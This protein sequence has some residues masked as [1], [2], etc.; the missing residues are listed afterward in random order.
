MIY[1]DH[2]ATS[3]LSP[4]S[5]AT[6][7]EA[8]E[9]FPGNPSSPHRLGARADAALEQARQRLASLLGCAPLD[10]VW[11]SGSTEA[12]NTVLHHAAAADPAAPA[13]IGAVEHPAVRESAR[14]HFRSRVDEIPVD[15]RGVVDL[16]WLKD[17]LAAQRPALV[18][19]MAANNETGVLQPWREAQELC[20]GAG[21]PFFCDATQWCGRLPA[22]GLGACGFVA[23][24]AHKFG[25]PRGVGFLKVP[26]AWPLRPLLWGGKQLEGRRAGTENV[27]GVL[28]MVA[29]LE[30]CEEQIA[31]G[32]NVQ[33]LAL[34]ERFQAALQ[35]AFP[36]V[37]L[38]GAGADRLWNTVSVVMPEADCRQ[39][40]VVKLDRAGFAVSTGSACASGS[41]QPSHVLTAMGL[42]SR[43]A[44]R[45]L[46][47]SSGWL[48]AE[49]EWNDLLKAMVRI[50]EDFAVSAAAI[51]DAP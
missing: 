45:A 42:S 50:Q 27:P 6:W 8:A 37:R 14:H 35:T 38:N 26:N 17:R 33:R 4:R 19:I 31:A 16:D 32:G 29:A 11:T 39:R 13:W 15:A 18:A 36:S 20:A 28:G 25:G 47:F 40:W 1:L 34:R 43:D 30:W 48:T 7:L 9:R 49:A 51:P 22:Q 21:I 2:N 23:G 41:E 3:P 24:S 10:I 44:S 5:R 46:R 12:C